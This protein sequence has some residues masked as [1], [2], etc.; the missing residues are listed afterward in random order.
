MNFSSFKIHFKQKYLYFVPVLGGSFYVV[1]KNV[2]F[3]L[4]KYKSRVTSS[5]MKYLRRIEEKQVKMK[6]NLGN[7]R[8]GK[9]HIEKTARDKRNGI[10]DTQ[11]NTEE[12]DEWI[13]GLTSNGNGEGEEDVE[14][15]ILKI[16]NLPILDGHFIFIVFLQLLKFIA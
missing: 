15:I 11:E 3:V 8:Q 16:A 4:H 12:R 7:R 10:N 14:S 13:N 6:L 2:M 9:Q 5:E 1:Q